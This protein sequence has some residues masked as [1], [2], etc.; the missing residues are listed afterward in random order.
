[1]GVSVVEP[2]LAR[3]CHETSTPIPGHPFK[4]QHIPLPYTHS[5]PH[6]RNAM[7]RPYPRPRDALSKPAA[8]V[9]AL[10]LCFTTL[11]WLYFRPWSS[12]LLLDPT[13]YHA[14]LRRTVNEFFPA[15][16]YPEL[17]TGLNWLESPNATI[18]AHLFQTD[19]NIP[20]AH[21]AESWIRHGFN[22]TFL[23]DSQAAQ[24]VE[25]HFRGSEVARV[26]HELPLPVMYV[27]TS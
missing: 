11:C 19:K 12:V 7:S 10:S 2:A 25:E 17:V 18:P 5:P 24:W 1:M 21:D 27:P 8:S 23:D 16:L 4:C 13:H 6:S 9:I 3:P 26:Y 14:T 20:N 22:R 15:N